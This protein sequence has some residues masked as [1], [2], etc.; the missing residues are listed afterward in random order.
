MLVKALA[1]LSSPYLPTSSEKVWKFLGQDSTI[2]QSG[3]SAIDSD[4]PYH[5]RLNESKPLFSKIEIEEDENDSMYAGF[6]TLN[7]KVGRIIEANDHPN[8]DSLLLLDVDIGKKIQ[9]V[10]GL[11][12]YYSKEEMEG[13]N[14][15]VVSNLK[16]ARIRGERSEGMLLAAD[17]DDIV[18]L[19]SPPADSKPGEPVNSG[20]NQSDR[21]VEF[22]DFQKLILRVAEVS[23][24]G[25]DI[26]RLIKASNPVEDG[27]KRVI[28]YMPSK[29]AEE[30]LVLATERG[31]VTVDESLPGGATVR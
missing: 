25:L 3:W 26:G 2:Q 6:E 5:Q 1:V 28:V 27:S 20:M 10:A 4:L 14:V 24:E 17:A 21:T 23:K 22:K 29:D 31:P 15:V 13:L 8:A 9:V 30:A 19:V 12:E 16:P 11:K 7:L 18:R